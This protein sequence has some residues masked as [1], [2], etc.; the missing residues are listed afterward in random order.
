[1]NKEKLK[2]NL[3]DISSSSPV[4][5]ALSTNSSAVEIEN[6]VRSQKAILWHSL[7]VK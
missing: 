6:I 2:K 5:Q 7:V 4:L 3:L 1:M